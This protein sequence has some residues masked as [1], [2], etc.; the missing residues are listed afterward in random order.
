MTDERR[1]QE[2]ER[3]TYSGYEGKVV[4]LY[5]DGP[6][7][8]ARMYDVRLTAGVICVCGSDLKDV[9]EEKSRD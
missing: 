8:S 6:R 2:G 5:S 7:E 3:V 9:D 4:R 1:R